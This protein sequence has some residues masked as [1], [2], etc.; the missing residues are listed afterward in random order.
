[1]G[2]LR[3]GLNLLHHQHKTSPVMLS[4]RMLNIEPRHGPEE[5]P[6]DLGMTHLIP[7][8][9]LRVNDPVKTKIPLELTPPSSKSSTRDSA[10]ATPKEVPPE[11][12][13][14]VSNS[15]GQTLW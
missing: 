8:G 12:I 11:A 3:L 4:M 5:D 2:T 9:M 10:E 15:F 13:Q 6:V 7:P 14:A 1:M